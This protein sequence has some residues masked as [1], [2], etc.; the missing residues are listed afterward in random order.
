MFMMG[1]AGWPDIGV[2]PLLFSMVGHLKYG[3]N[4]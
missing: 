2:Q 4:L 3:L 1:F